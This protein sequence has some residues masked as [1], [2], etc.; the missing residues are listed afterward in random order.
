MVSLYYFDRLAYEP[1]SILLLCRERLIDLPFEHLTKVL[2]VWPKLAYRTCQIS[3]IGVL[4]GKIHTAREEFDISC[5][6][7]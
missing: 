5:Q 7:C 6:I 3:G 4:I 2:F 1:N